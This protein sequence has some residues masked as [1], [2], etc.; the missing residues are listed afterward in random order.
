[1]SNT[2]DLLNKLQNTY[3]KLDQGQWSIVELESMVELSRELHERAVILRYKA[4]EQKVFDQKVETAKNIETQIDEVE[5]NE[6]IQEE[7]IDFGIFEKEEEPAP[8]SEPTFAFD[9]LKEEEVV[10]MEPEVEEEEE[11]MTEVE[12]ESPNLESDQ[13]PEL[14]EEIKETVEEEVE[15][16]VETGNW[17]SI[18]NNIIRSNESS[19]R[20]Q[21]S[22]LSGSFGM[23]ERLLYINELFDGDADHFSD[24]IKNLDSKSTWEESLALV[25]HVATRENWIQDSE[26]VQEFIV[27][28]HRKYV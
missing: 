3:A 28:L 5:A 10:E 22:S 13:E 15:N 16:F 18:I 12:L 11:V 27:H 19:F 6:P 4:F 1:M 25:E 20:S 26:T 17:N 24:L 21:L 8:A 7:P 9:M 23:N 14:P 2:K